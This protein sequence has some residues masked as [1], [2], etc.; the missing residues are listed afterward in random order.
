MLYLNFQV[1]SVVGRHSNLEKISFLGHSLG[2]LV[3]R[4]AIAVL[5]EQDST[6]K[7]SDENGECGEDKLSKS[8]VEE[9]TRAKIAGLEPMNF[10]TCATPHLGAIGHRQVLLI[11]RFSVFSIYLGMDLLQLSWIFCLD[12]LLL[13]YRAFFADS[14][15]LRLSWL[16]ESSIPCFKCSAPDREASILER[17]RQRKTSPSPSD[18]W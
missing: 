1:I 18:G 16:G 6:R 13:A 7:A 14:G 8:D 5:Y 4:Y 2:G 15:A 10:I 12:Y 3:A 17:Q 11:T 9:K